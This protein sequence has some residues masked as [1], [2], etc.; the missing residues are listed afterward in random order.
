MSSSDHRRLI[1]SLAA[2]AGLSACGYRPVLAPGGPGA[3]LIGRVALRD[4]ASRYDFALVEALDAR[5]GR[6]GDGAFRLD[7]SIS[8]RSE[9]VAVTQENVTTRYNL[10]APVDYRLLAAEG[11]RVAS[12]SVTSFGSYSASGTVNATEAA[13]RDA[14]ARLMRVLA[15]SVVTRLYAELAGQAA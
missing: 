1:L 5:L 8:V 2:L 11:G 6:A 14:E 7:F 3:G 10:V 4:P 12:G 15:D 13:Q 9:R